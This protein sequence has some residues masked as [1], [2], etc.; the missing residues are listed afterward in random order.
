MQAER[1]WAEAE[2]AALGKRK[3]ALDAQF[4]ALNKRKAA[5]NARSSV[6]NVWG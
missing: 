3:A 6:D 2:R 1:R 5:L 4:E